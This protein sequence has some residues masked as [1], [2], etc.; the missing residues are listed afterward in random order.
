ME[1]EEES[2][3]MTGTLTLKRKAQTREKDA[4]LEQLS[5]KL[6]TDDNG[7]IHS[8]LICFNITY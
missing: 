8:S 5:K 2:K 4:K 3:P 1:I 7:K 6:K